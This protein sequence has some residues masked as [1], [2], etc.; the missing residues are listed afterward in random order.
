MSLFDRTLVYPSDHIGPYVELDGTVTNVRS[1]I[2]ED[3]ALIDVQTI[4]G[5][6]TGVS[7]PPFPEVGY[8]ARIR[9]YDAG[10]GFYPDNRVTGWSRTPV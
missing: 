8:E 5:L 3:E 7:R 6:F 2:G 1:L 9:I 10:G 4:K